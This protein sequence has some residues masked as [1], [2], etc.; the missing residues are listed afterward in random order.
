[1]AI[2]GELRDQL[3]GDAGTIRTPL[4][5]WHAW[6]QDPALDEAILERRVQA[7]KLPLKGESMRK[8]NGKQSCSS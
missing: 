6:L 4:E 1:L 3:R 8:S 5:H 7:H 2:A